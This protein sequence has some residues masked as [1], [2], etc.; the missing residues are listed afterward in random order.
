MIR[1]RFYFD[2]GSVS[3]LEIKGDKGLFF[4]AENHLKADYWTVVDDEGNPINREG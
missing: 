3:D 1:V 2:D 4:F